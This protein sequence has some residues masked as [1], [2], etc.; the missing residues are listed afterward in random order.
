[1]YTSPAELFIYKIIRLCSPAEVHGEVYIPEQWRL[2]VTF[3]FLVKC[4]SKKE[5]EC[6][7]LLKYYYLVFF[8]YILVVKSV[9][10][11]RFKG[12]Q[13]D[14]RGLIKGT[15]PGWSLLTIYRRLGLLDVFL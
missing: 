11:N 10:Y 12:K 15:N 8:T 5:L 2:V 3:S 4:T 6:W 14:D 7:Q 9:K 1:M 13:S